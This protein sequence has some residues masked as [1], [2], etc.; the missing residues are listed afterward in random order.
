MRGSS[1]MVALRKHWP[2][3]PDMAPLSSQICL[4]LIYTYNPSI[5]V[6]S[7]AKCLHHP[8]TLSSNKT[9]TTTLP[10][11]AT[12]PVLNA[13]N[14]LSSPSRVPYKN[15]AHILHSLAHAGC[16]SHTPMPVYSPKRTTQS[17]VESGIM[18]LRNLFST[19]MN[20]R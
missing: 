18:L 2:R 4:P 19:H 13:Q 6:S 16:G 7:S 10:P 14:F 1:G 15:L 9:I 12:V 17:D 3:C 5:L 11:Q 20:C 8:T